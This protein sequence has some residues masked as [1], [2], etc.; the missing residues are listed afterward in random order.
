M[1]TRHSIIQDMNGCAPKNIFDQ[2]RQLILGLA[3][4]H[5]IAVATGPANAIDKSA[6]G[7]ARQHHCHYLCIMTPQTL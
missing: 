7:C 2:Q 4:A 3:A 6:S 1:I 5:M